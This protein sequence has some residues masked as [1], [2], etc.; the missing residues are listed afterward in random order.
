[1][2]PFRTATHANIAGLQVLLATAVQQV[3]VDLVLSEQLSAILCNL[4][5]NLNDLYL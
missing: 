5:Q 1:M 3:G 4:A 2:G